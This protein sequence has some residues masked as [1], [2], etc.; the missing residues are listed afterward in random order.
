MTRTLVISDKLYAWLE[1]TA[2]KRHLNTIEEL[3]EV[4]KADEDNIRERVEIVKQIDTLRERL[5]A[6]YGE[7]PD[8]TELI[9]E[10]RTR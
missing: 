5:F 3:L 8:S 10:D 6:K 4:W 7:T 1:T 2:Q 9:Q